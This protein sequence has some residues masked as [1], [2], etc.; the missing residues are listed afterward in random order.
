MTKQDFI[1]KL[2]RKSFFISKSTNKKGVV[3]IISNSIN[4]ALLNDSFP[5]TID[6]VANVVLNYA[7]NLHKDNQVVVSTPWYPNVQDNYPFPVIRYLSCKSSPKIGYRMGISLNPK[8]IHQ[9]KKYNFDIIH[10]HCPFSSAILARI[11]RGID[12]HSI[13]E[14]K[15][16][17]IVFTYHTKFSYDLEKRLKSPLAQ[18]LSTKFILNNINACD[19][20]WVV[21]KGAGEDLKRLGYKGEYSL[22]RNGTD[23]KRGKSPLNKIKN[24]SLLLGLNPNEPIFLFVGRI[25]WYKG[26]KLIID[27]L[28]ILKQRQ[29][30]FKMIFV[31][32]GLDKMELEQYILEQGLLENCLLVGSLND[33]E[34]LRT[35]YSLADLFLF[36][37]N[38]DTNG[39]VVNEAAACALPSVT[40]KNSC[41]S[42]NIIANRTGLLID[43][44]PQELAN[45][46][47]LAFQNPALLKIM[48]QYA[49][50]ELYLSWEDA[51]L[52]AYRKYEQI[53][54]KN[55][56]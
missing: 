13:K 20:V 43:N 9:L 3:L 50:K 18:R 19:E 8:L 38:Y 42:E 39:M 51:I 40:L 16:A 15:N 6:G 30:N 29:K 45:A 11:L 22:M 12:N 33:R 27:G 5:P 31:G 49:K 54:A 25:M 10:T 34:A 1:S 35:Y 24:L 23:F 17:P 41:A 44:T 46:L 55:F 21:S 48:G 53:L 56:S 14:A 36:P 37:S 7:K 47:E 28:K 2:L 4:I 32:D 26:L 52:A